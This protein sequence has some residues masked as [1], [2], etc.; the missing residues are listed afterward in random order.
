M[1]NLGMI[2][3]LIGLSLL[4]YGF[5][6]DTSVSVDYTHGNMLGLPERVYNIGLVSE[7]QNYLISG[8]VLFILGIITVLTYDNKFAA[9]SVRKKSYQK[10]TKIKNYLAIDHSISDEIMKSLKN[11]NRL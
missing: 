1:K 10:A 7:K 5:T 9:K 8:L 4:A 11:I 3:F 6:I 2:I